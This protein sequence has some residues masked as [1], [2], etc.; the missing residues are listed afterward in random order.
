MDLR[1]T[2]PRVVDEVTVRL[3]AAQ[4]LVVTTL[5][6]ATGWLWLFA[7]LAVDFTLRVLLGPRSPLAQ[8]ALRVLR[9]LVPAA[10][11]PT[12]GPPKRFAATIGAVCSLLVV[13]F[14][15][16]L[17]WTVAAWVVVAMM[18]AFPFLEAVFGLCVGCTVFALAMR[19]GLVPE[20]VCLDCADISRRT[21][22]ATLR[23]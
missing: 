9:P 1:S 2:F 5:A 19:A 10:P 16:G 8:V 11:R 15:Y 21:S 3:V 7:L 17:G 14:A 22:A 13:L 18:V 6:A 23:G 12:P 4:V 20:E